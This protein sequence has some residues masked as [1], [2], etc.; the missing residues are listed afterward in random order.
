MREKTAE[1]KLRE[2]LEGD[3]SENSRDKE[4]VRR[5][6]AKK[7]ARTS[8]IGKKADSFIDD[9]ER[10]VEQSLNAGNI[11]K[12]PSEVQRQTEPKP[13]AVKK[14]ASETIPAA[15][16]SKSI[17]TPE[18]K[19][20]VEV[21]EYEI[22]PTPEPEQEIIKSEILPDPIK[23]E[24]EPEILKEPT[25]SGL[26]HEIITPEVLPTPEPEPE[27]IEPEILPDP[28]K[29][30]EESEILPEPIKPEPEPEITEPEI[31]PEP[32]EPEIIEPEAPVIEAIPEAPIVET[33]PEIP[34]VEPEILPEPVEA[35]LEPE[36]PPVSEPSEPEPEILPTSEIDEQEQEILPEPELQE[37]E[38]EIS[39][40]DGELPDIPVIEPDELQ[41]INREENESEI[42]YGELPDIP[43]IEDDIEEENNVDDTEENEEEISEEISSLPAD[44]VVNVDDE[45]PELPETFT[46]PDP[47]AEAAPVSVTMP[48][49]TKTAEDKLMADIAEAM[50]GSPLNLD[51]P[52]APAPYQLPDNF[53][54]ANLEN[55]DPSQ[56]SAEDK[57]IANIA[58]AMN[59]SP[60][61]TAQEQTHQ[62]LEQDL[63]PFDEI[64]F[65][66]PIHEA[67]ETSEIDNETQEP[68]I[69]EPETE[70]Q[71][72]EQQDEQEQAF[73]PDF[74]DENMTQDE[75]PEELQDETH[76]ETQDEPEIINDAEDQEADEQPSEPEP[77]PEEPTPTLELEPEP[78]QEEQTQDDENEALSL[79]PEEAIAMLGDD[80]DAEEE[81]NEDKGSND[82]EPEIL[83]AEQ[84]LQQEIANFS[85]AQPENEINAGI[86]SPEINIDTQENIHEE[87]Q[88]E[89]TMPEQ[90]LL[91][92]S[93]D[94]NEIE[95][96]N[97]D[98]WDISSL[99][100]LSEAASIPDD[101]PE[102]LTPKETP[103]TIIMDN[104]EQAEQEKTMGI[105][106]KLAERKNAASAKKSSTSSSSSSS[107]GSRGGLL[108]PILLGL[109]LLLGGVIAWQLH[110][111]SDK[112]TLAMMNSAG[113]EN[114]SGFEAPPSYDYTIDFILDPNITERMT[115][116]GREGW[117]VVGSRRTQDST[118]GQYGYEFI[119]MRRRSGR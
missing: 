113:F 86:I 76:D 53:L 80:D 26:Q 36:I 59:E 103:T 65:S 110:Q 61:D 97:G 10:R 31:L 43:V 73:L 47:E 23:S 92:N 77:E 112:I 95:E 48:E 102:D 62:D 56:Q 29:P 14:L 5:L 50:T 100:A 72:E 54:N 9:F 21:L 74:S 81:A 91:D 2:E 88:P 3:S 83:T 32:I 109:L 13:R 82:D 11:F 40:P 106:E 12:T 18:P 60:L 78:E 98:D 17:P 118:T 63:N 52:E 6:R 16:K 49:S 38:P 19:P 55:S 90:S 116:R 51:S 41:D 45:L 58:Q 99:G 111:I 69:L 75:P 104:S 33:E 84:R 114:V 117:Q 46:E 30:E 8:N 101:D 107:G 7:S 68:E 64:N 89:N 96:E 34:V 67:Q 115:A 27:I 42:S 94:I 57:L 119:F 66:A 1:E 37:P 87:V 85:Q 20:K 79:S 39:E 70:P 25:V 15:Q 4:L 24:Q 105:R 22:L 28:V 44:I 93:Q 35:E 71:D 108:L